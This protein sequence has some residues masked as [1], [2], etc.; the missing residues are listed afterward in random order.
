MT[1]STAAAPNRVLLGG[2]CAWLLVTLLL[3]WCL[4]GLGYEVAA[5]QALFPGKFSRLLQAHIDFLLMS[6]LLLGFYAA[7]VPLPR[8]ASLAMVIGAFTNSSLFL[9]MAMFPVLDFT[10][11]PP[12]HPAQGVYEVYLFA[13]LSLTTFGFATAAIT[14][15]RCLLRHQH[16]RPAATD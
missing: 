15:L 9:L 16:T 6:A 12:P 10:T 14:V 11:R 1:E 7:R 2:A 5:V 3:A 8:V 4:V 13:S